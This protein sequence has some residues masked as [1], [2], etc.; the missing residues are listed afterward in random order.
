MTRFV[1]DASAAIYLAS[2]ADGTI[3]ERHDC[4]APPLMWSESVSALSEAAYRGQ[5]P[6]DALVPAIERL[7]RLPIT[8]AGGRPEDRRAALEIARALGWAKTY[9]AEY[10]ALARSLDCALLSIDMRLIQG[11]ARLI[12]FV[13]PADL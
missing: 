12:E 9:D 6:P 3:L 7:E 11:A 8:S 10:V 5:L 1:V 2:M 13:G 4:S